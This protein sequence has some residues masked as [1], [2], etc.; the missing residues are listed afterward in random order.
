MIVSIVAALGGAALWDDV[1]HIG[2][3]RRIRLTY[4]RDG[5]GAGAEED[6]LLEIPPLSAIAA[7]GQ[8]SRWGQYESTGKRPDE[9]RRVCP[10]GSGAAYSTISSAPTSSD[11]GTVRPIAL[12]VLRLMPSSNRVGACTGRS[13]AFSPL[14]MRST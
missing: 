5:P 6:K 10:T 11:C 7:A 12:A 9:T 2:R 14:R 4:W 3:P 1:S 13:P 8:G